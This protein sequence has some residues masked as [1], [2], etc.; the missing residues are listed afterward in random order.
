[1][2]DSASRWLIVKNAKTFRSYVKHFLIFP[3]EKISRTLNDLFKKVFMNHS[4]MFLDRDNE[5][6]LVPTSF[7]YFI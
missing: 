5:I 3:R 1:M 7:S 6:K 4:I 2:C